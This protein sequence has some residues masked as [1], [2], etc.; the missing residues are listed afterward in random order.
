MLVRSS[1]PGWLVWAAFPLLLLLAA[2]C[3]REQREKAIGEGYVGANNVALRDQLGA[4]WQSLGTLQVGE[5]VE[6]LQRRRRMVRVR[7]AAGTEGWLEERHVISSELYQRAQ[8]LLREAVARPSQGQARARAPANLHLEPSRPSPRLFQLE[9]GE[10]CDVLEH[11]A[12]ERPL[13]PG[14]VSQATS[15]PESPVPAQKGRKRRASQ[16]S[17]PKMEDWLLVRGKAKA[18]WALARF[19]EMAVPPEVAP[20]AEGR[21]ITAWQVLNEVEDGEEKKP[22]YVWATSQKVGT[23]HDFD[24]LRVL[25]WNPAR[26]RY[27][28]AY[29]EWSLRGLYPLTVGTEN[30]DGSQVPAFAI[31]TLDRDGKRVTRHYVLVG[32]KVRRKQ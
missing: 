23:P 17:G 2:G 27:E 3:S 15:L 26:D 22:Q 10:L 14:A 16:A 6:I 30:L 28:V 9:Q 19:V 4:G 11:R 21:A 13:P 1:R 7:T 25:T 18:G 5:R 24:G 8:E 29:Q 32:N 12:V 31:S 20:L